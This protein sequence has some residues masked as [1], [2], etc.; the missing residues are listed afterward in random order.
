MTCKY[1]VEPASTRY[2]LPPLSLYD[3]PHSTCMTF[4]KFGEDDVISLSLFH[5]G[6]FIWVPK[7]E[8]IGGEVTVYYFGDLDM[9]TMD[10]LRA[11]SKALGYGGLRC[12]YYR[13]PKE[14]L[15]GGL[16]LMSHEGRLEGDG[17]NDVGDW[18]DE[19]DDYDLSESNYSSEDDDM[20]FYKNVLIPNDLT[21]L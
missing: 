15:D 8:Y 10:N 19:L 12:L 7:T 5:G 3:L 6:R 21:E 9:I 20:L 13:K 2:D 14:E 1:S 18:S 11:W 4:R 16:V 17:S